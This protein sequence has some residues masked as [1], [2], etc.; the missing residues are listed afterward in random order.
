MQTRQMAH[1]S[2]GGCGRPHVLPDPATGFSGG[3]VME[4]WPMQ[5]R[6]CWGKGYIEPC[7][8]C[9][10]RWGKECKTCGGANRVKC[11]V[12]DGKGSV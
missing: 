1:P 4:D 9:R 8:T 5:C 10:G 7:P 11:G 2:G 12:C 6:S 3:M